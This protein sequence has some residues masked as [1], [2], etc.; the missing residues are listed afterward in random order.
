MKHKVCNRESICFPYGLGILLQS[1]ILQSY[2]DLSSLRREMS[3]GRSGIEACVQRFVHF[4]A[5]CIVID[6]CK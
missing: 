1:E 2:M 4:S 5:P 3:L 6:V